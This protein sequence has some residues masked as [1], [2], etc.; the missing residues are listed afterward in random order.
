M[1][2]SR[3]WDMPHKHT[4]KIP[5]VQSILR[6]FVGNGIGWADPFANDHS[7][8]EFTND[9]NP[10]TLAK[11]HMD[12]HDFLQSFDDGSLNGLLLDPPYSMH[13]V[14]ASYNGYGKAMVS[15]LTPV[16]DEA[17]RIA[18]VGG[19]VITFGWNSNG[20]GPG[21]GFEMLEVIMIP[22]G[23]HHNDTIVTV[24]RRVALTS[25]LFAA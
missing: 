10:A 15:A 6:R 20:L 1:I 7:H 14:T 11:Q 22:H 19:H 9:L 25:E 4:F 18:Q 24:E 12:A 5:A 8:V 16:Y 21:R 17:S 3:I 2:I 23:G 13:Q